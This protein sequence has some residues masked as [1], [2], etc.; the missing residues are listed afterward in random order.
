MEN[1][2]SIE[3]KIEFDTVPKPL[4]K[5]FELQRELV[6]WIKAQKI[7]TIVNFE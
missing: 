3:Q 2:S 1:K 4:K 6:V 7:I 5:S